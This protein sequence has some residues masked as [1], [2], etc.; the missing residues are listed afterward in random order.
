MELWRER[1]CKGNEIKSKQHQAKMK[2]R[3]QIQK[4]ER[5]ADNRYVSI[6]E[7]ELDSE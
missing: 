6:E 3:M 1:V 4:Q 5:D 7:V 2:S